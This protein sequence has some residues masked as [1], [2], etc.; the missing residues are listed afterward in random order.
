MYDPPRDLSALLPDCQVDHL[1]LDKRSVH[2]QL[3]EASRRGYAIFV[4]LCEGYL[5][6]DIPSVDVIWSLEALELPYTGPSLR[7]YDPSKPL[8]KYVAYTQG[9]KSPPCVEVNT[10]DDCEAAL[11]Q[12]RFPLFVKP[13]HAGDSLG[14]DT[15]SRV[16]DA[17][18][19]RAQCQQV[20]D[21]FGSALVEEFIPGREFTVLVV[22]NPNK[23]FDPTVLRPLEFVFEHPDAFKTYDLKIREHHPEA[24][25]PLQ[26]QELD[27]SLRQAAKAIF[28]GFSGEGYARLDFR[29]DAQGSV[30]FIDI[31]FAC[32]VFY[33][34]GHEGSADY[35]LKSD[36][37]TASGFLRQIIDEGKA[38]HRS[39]R[40]RWVRRGNAISG[41]GIY[42][43]EAIQQGETVFRFEERA[44]RLVSFPHVEQHWP[45]DQIE[46][47]RRYALPLN[48]HV[49]LLWDD[50]PENWAPQNHS[51]DP[52]TRY[53]GLNVVAVRDIAAGEELTLDY[54]T[55]CNDGMIPF[56]CQCN[57]PR[58]RK[59]IRGTASVVV[60][61]R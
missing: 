14:I 17:N 53:S 43:R 20:I 5:D 48:S 3:R 29:V 9:V 44:Q 47:F 52:N 40:R 2:R 19:L 12:L 37:L 30:F 60:G 41:Y 31:N 58:C 8:M 39:R 11:T 33:A 15:N 24:N 36:A 46:I 56:E 10:P 59:I 7:V 32:S 6:W 25:V 22:A 50:Q 16:Q 28:V 38:R 35:I 21:R 51:C 23:P 55:I 4:N 45:A 57:S 1:F 13:A 49:S 42:A 61:I 26:D 18:G 34:E 27:Q 54:A